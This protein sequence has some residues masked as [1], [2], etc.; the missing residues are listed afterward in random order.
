MSDI[1]FN[2]GKASSMAD[3]IFETDGV[4]LRSLRRYAS[5]LTANTVYAVVS[6]ITA[7][8]NILISGTTTAIT[9]SLNPN[10]TTTSITTTTSNSGTIFSAGTDLYDIFITTNDGNDITRV[11]PG[12]NTYTGGT[13]NF[14]TV[15]ISG[16]TFDSITS[17][18]SS[19]F[20]SLS[21]STYYSGST[22]LQTVI[23]SIV[24]GNTTS[25]IARH[26]LFMG[27]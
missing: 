8:S 12:L 6:G 15:N 4:N 1:N 9:I 3:A 10:V 5:I 19:S 2:G 18:G 27:G 20:N 24:T 25:S 13:A 26:F 14:P 16:G 23:Y 22:P 7:G 11:Q 21:A 17:S